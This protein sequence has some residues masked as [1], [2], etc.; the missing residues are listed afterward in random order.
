ME[1]NEQQE[2][3][4]TISL[5]DFFIKHV[6]LGKLNISM[7]LNIGGLCVSGQLISAKQYYNGLKEEISNHS[8]QIEN[9]NEEAIG[10]FTNF[11]D[12]VGQSVP[13]DKEEL[14]KY[15]QKYIYLKDARFYSGFR[16]IPFKKGV[17]WMGKLTSVDGF[18]IGTLK[19]AI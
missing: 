5:L 10:S 9:K 18:C 14:V 3:E 4:D 13:N 16:A 17:L 19:E 2:N 15:N 1:K 6:T 11:F 12:T 8:T 7:T